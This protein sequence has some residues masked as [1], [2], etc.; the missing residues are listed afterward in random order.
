VKAPKGTSII[1]A[2][3]RD[4]KETGS[5]SSIIFLCF[6]VC[7]SEGALRLSG[8]IMAIGQAASQ[9]LILIFTDIAFV[10]SML[11]GHSV[12]TWRMFYKMPAEKESNPEIPSSGRR[13]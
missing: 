9:K 12:R 1:R 3:T 2:G 6:K 8:F 5:S 4:S 11:G 13:A 10:S 7:T